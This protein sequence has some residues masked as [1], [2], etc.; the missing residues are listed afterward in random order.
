MEESHALDVGSLDWGRRTRGTLSASERRALRRGVLRDTRV[1]ARSRMLLAVRGGARSATAD[2][3]VMDLPDSALCRAVEEAA[4]R[5]QSATM[6]AH[7]YRTVAYAHA[8]GTL[9]GVRPDPELLWCASLLHDVALEQPV[10]G[11]CFAVRGGEL[12]EQVALDAGADA[13]TARLLG[14]AVA[15]HATADLDPATHPLPYLVAA[16]ALVDV[17]GKRLEQVDPAFVAAVTARRPRGDFARLLARTWR[18]EARAVP[19]GRAAQVHRTTGFAFAA[20][21]A[22]L[23]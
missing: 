13:A 18:A 19:A 10:A 20:R 21:F 12:A 8:L 1:Y 3:A 4:A 15:R 16:G 14:D 6:L 23:R 11:H 5:H 17:L 9:D 7:G 22:P 2:L